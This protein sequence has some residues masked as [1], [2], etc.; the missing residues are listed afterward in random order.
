MVVTA[1]S[2]HQELFER[3]AAAG[4][5]MVLVPPRDLLGHRGNGPI[6]AA[7]EAAPED[8][9]RRRPVA[10][11][12]PPAARRPRRGRQ[13]RADLPRARVRARP[14]SSP[15]R[16]GPADRLDRAGERR[17]RAV[18]DLLARAPRD[19]RRATT[20][21]TSPAAPIA[22]AR[23]ASSPAAATAS[24]AR[25]S[26]RGV[27]A[28]VSGEP[29]EPAM[30]DAREAGVHFIAA[31]HWA[32]ETFG[33]RRLGDLLAEAFRRRARV[34]RR[35]E[36][37]LKTACRATSGASERSISAQFRAI[38]LVTVRPIR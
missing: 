35:P 32:S 9:V 30:A 24:S 37:G 29:S 6:D 22:S 12:L 4:A 33:I 10:G 3:A 26:T 17:R 36:S 7:H 2:A 15:P 21:C 34:R 20:S 11:R 31:G 16:R 8:A 25:R 23:S 13:Q 5:Q 28:F 27:D 19:L 1:V 18:D 14:S 38:S